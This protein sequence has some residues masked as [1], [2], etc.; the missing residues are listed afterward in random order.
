M[1]QKKTGSRRA[2]GAR[3]DNHNAISLLPS[4]GPGFDSLL[5]RIYYNYYLSKRDDMPALDLMSAYVDE[6]QVDGG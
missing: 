3:H 6:N 2:A 4:L 1:I 5:S